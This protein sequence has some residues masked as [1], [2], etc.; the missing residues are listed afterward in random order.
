MRNHKFQVPRHVY[1]VFARAF[2][3]KA[4]SPPPGGRI[5]RSREL[6]FSDLADRGVPPS[7]SRG[8]HCPSSSRGQWAGLTAFWLVSVQ[9]VSLA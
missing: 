9:P 4:E 8:A 5:R 7:P 3:R 1:T 6:R 2:Q